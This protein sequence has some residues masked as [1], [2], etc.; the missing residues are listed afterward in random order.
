MNGQG[1]GVAILLL[2]TVSMRGAALLP[3]R[4]RTSSDHRYRSDPPISA[5]T[6]FLT[7]YIV[8]YRLICCPPSACPHTTEWPTL[9]A[10]PDTARSHPT[11]IRSAPPHLASPY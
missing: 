2:P 4:G 10:F 9:T 1:G 8:Y 5:H 3:T 6:R 11:L 7:E